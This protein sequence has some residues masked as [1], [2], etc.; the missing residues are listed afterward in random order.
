MTVGVSGVSRRALHPSD[1]R[2]PGW[3][4]QA[5]LQVVAHEGAL[6]DHGHDQG[7]GRAVS[8]ARRNGASARV[9]SLRR[10]HG[11]WLLCPGRAW[12]AGVVPRRAFGCMGCCSRLP[13]E[14]PPRP[15]PPLRIL[16][17]SESTAHDSRETE[18]RM[19]H[20]KHCLGNY[21]T[22]VERMLARN[23]ST[24]A[25]VVSKAAIQRTT[26]WRSSQRWK[27]QSRCRAAMCRG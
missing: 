6:A 7:S 12:G 10:T 17:S 8:R 18:L 3:A 15:L 26:D 21:S 19:I 13:G 24:S 14:T 5:H 9:A 27:V 1:P 16:S 25:S 11:G 20:V 2:V 23:V 4:Q 22:A